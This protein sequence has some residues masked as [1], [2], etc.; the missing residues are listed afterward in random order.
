MLR[1]GDTV[2]VFE[3]SR[4]GRTAIALS[5]LL[6]QWSDSGIGLN[7]LSQPEFSFKAGSELTTMQSLMLSVMAH[8]AQME[9]ELRKERQLSGI[10]AAKERGAYKGKQMNKAL[11]QAVRELVQRGVSINKT[12][13]IAGCSRTTVTSIRKQ[14]KE[15]SS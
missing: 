3:L 7:V 12:A 2:A 10:Q 11:H 5:S 15:E 8:V 13:E 14:M 1:T 4:L 9:T 6:K